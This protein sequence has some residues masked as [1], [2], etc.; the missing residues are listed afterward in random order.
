MKNKNL[1]NWYSRLDFLVLDILV[2]QIS[3]V[4]A[5]TIKEHDYTLLHY[6]DSYLKFSIILFLISSL[7]GFV[8]GRYF[9]VL[10][11]GYLDELKESFIYICMVLLS[12]SMVLFIQK[13]S[14]HYS[15][16]IVL[17]LWIIGFALCYVSRCIWKIC[18]RKYFKVA[19]SWRT[20]L[21]VVTEDLLSKTISDIKSNKYKNFWISAVVVLD[22]KKGSINSK[23]SGCNMLYG[24]ENINDF[25]K[26]HVVDE[27]LI[28]VSNTSALPKDLIDNCLIAGVITHFDV[29]TCTSYAEGTLGDFN[30]YTVATRGMAVKEPVHLFVKRLMDIF[31]SIVGLFLTAIVSI[32][33]IP[34]IKIADPGPAFFSQVRVGKNGRKFKI[35]KFR[36]MYTDAEQ[37]KESLMQHNEMNGLMFKMENDPRII[38]GIGHFIRKTSIDELPQFLNVL[39]GDMSVV[40]T[41]PPTES[42]YENYELKHCRRLAL[43]PGITGL[44]QVSGRNKISD[45]EDIVEIDSQYI[46]QWSLKLDAKIIFK[47][48]LEVFSGSGA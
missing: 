43:K 23:L 38:K 13:D 14:E 24:A 31:V 22:G 39:S 10:E 29:L 30:G 9:A 40:G 7:T 5:Y 33:V 28:R 41:R 27:V 25:L 2:L 48:F 16:Q 15:R 8:R 11:R 19:K 17:S 3:C 37:R 4:F 26:E 44:W 42:E 47:T 45:F 35:Y 21:L 1:F 6:S 46:N 18:I 12:I 36:S 20:V 34:A 32:F